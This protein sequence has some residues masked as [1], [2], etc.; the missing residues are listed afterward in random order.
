MIVTEERPR[1][2]VACEESG[3]VTKALRDNGINAYS[4]DL[5][6]TSGDLPKYHYQ[7]DVNILLEDFKWDCI[8]AFPPCTH[9]CSSGARHFDKKREDGR[10]KD[11]IDFFYKFINANCDYIAIEN[12][13][14]I[15]SGDYIKKWFD[16]EPLKPTQI[17]QP[18]EYGDKFQKTTCLWL[19]GLPKLEPLTT[20]KPQMEFK[21]WVD[22]KGIKERQ[23]LW[24]YE[25]LTKAKTPEERSI[26]RS[27]TF[28]G[29]ANAM[30]KQWGDFLKGVITND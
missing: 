8:I 5:L 12:L 21:E 26:I 17:I 6:P 1:V 10:Q 16:I 13:V 22:D 23:S 2:L 14:G 24:F 11:A 15:I 9:L 30:G 28:D 20:E 27:K 3:K 7:G 29:I 18:W 19:K 25:A 4:C